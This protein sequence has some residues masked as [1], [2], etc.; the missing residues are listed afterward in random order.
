MG[1]LVGGLNP[2]DL[3]GIPAEAFAGLTPEGMQSISPD[4]V[5]VS[6]L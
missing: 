1:K 3:K 4:A 5:G 6:T 2:E